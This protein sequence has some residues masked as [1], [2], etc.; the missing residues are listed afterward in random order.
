M[1]RYQTEDHFDLWSALPS[2]TGWK[3]WK[4]QENVLFNFI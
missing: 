2:R 3:R 1:Y 4:L